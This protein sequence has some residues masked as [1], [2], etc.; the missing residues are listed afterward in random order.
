M[1]IGVSLLVAAIA[2]AAAQ[3]A[4]PR[5]EWS[6][7]TKGKIYASPIIAD[8]EN[9]GRSE[10]I[11]CA[12]RDRRIICFDGSGEVR[13]DYQLHDA[14]GDGIQA[15]PSV[16]D[17]DGDGRKEVFFADE[18]GVVGCL[19]YRGNVVWRV[20]T[21][22]RVDYSGPVVA[23]VNGDGRVEVIF[24]SDS[25]T[26][27][28]LDDAGIE[29][30][31]Y[32]GNGS[33]RGIPAVLRDPATSTMRIYVTFSGGTAACLSSEGKVLWSR[34]EPNAAKPRRSGPALGDLDGDGRIEMVSATGD[35]Q[36]IA[37]D[38]ITGEERWRWKGLL[39]ID[40][41][42]SFALADFD[43]TG[44][45]DV[46]CGDGAGLGGPGHVYRL[47]DGKALWTADVRGG[48]VQGP[49]IGDVDGD[50]ALEIMVCTRENRLVCLSQD[51]QE[52][53]DFPSMAG[54][55]T[56]PAI[57]DV[58]ADGKTEIVFTSKDG[59]VR[60]VTVDGA[61]H[62]DRLPWPC[63]NHDPQL[64]G[65]MNGAAFATTMPAPPSQSPP[66]LKVS[67]FG[68]LRTGENRVEVSFANL[69]Y[70]PRHLE[71]VAE[72]VGPN[73]S[74][75][76]RTISR[77]IQPYSEDLA[78]IA[79]DAFDSGEYLLSVR[80]L[81]VGAG[82]IL[83]KKSD[84]ARFVPL[85]W[86]KQAITSRLRQASSLLSRLHDER[87]KGRAAKAIAAQ[88]SGLEELSRRDA[89][90]AQRP[91]GAPA[92]PNNRAEVRRLA[93]AAHGILRECDRITARLTAA[94]ATPGANLD[95]AAVPV[96]TLR[97]L[98]R[99]EPCLTS[100]ADLSPCEI[101]VAGN[102]LEGIQLVVVPLWKDIPRLRVAVTDAVHSNGTARI[103]AEDIL[104]NRV[105]YV[106]VGPPEYNWY[107]EKRGFY[108]DVLF[109]A[110]PF[111][112]PAD[113]D[114]QPYFV[115]VRAR[116][117][118]VPGDY[119]AAVVFQ[120]EGCAPVTTPLKI[121]VWD[122]SISKETHLKTSLWINEGY[123]QRFYKYQGRTPFEVRK[124]YYD[125]QLEHR[126]GP[127]MALPYGGGSVLEDFDYV[128]S[129]GQNNFFVHVPGYIAESARAP[130]A[131]KLRAIHELIKAKGWNDRALF[132][133]RDEVAVMARHEI[134]Q[135][136]EMNN[137]TRSIVP[138][139]PRLETSAPE[140]SLF[141]AVDIWCPTIDSFDPA[142]LAQ[143]RAKG[144]RLWFYTVWGRPGIMIEFPATD[145]RLMFWQ[146][147]KYGAEGFLYW[148][149]T[150][151]DLNVTTERRWPDI[152]WIPYNRQPGHNGCGYLIYPGPNG[153]PLGSL[154]FELVRDGIEDFEY[155]YLLRQLL[156]AAGERVPAQLRARAEAEIAVSPE[157]VVDH[158]IFTEDPRVILNARARIAGLI[159]Q[160]RNLPAR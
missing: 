34:D 90:V 101:A 5:L 16:V 112:V 3:G 73:Q 13:W 147:W 157:V 96:T 107:V 127:L 150:H 124:R 11:V 114:A 60:S 71:L 146:C 2:A 103:P 66:L 95:F 20:F 139:W 47:R 88:Q 158:K 98:F 43:G 143:R 53:W 125:Y 59:F 113:Q 108:P 37:C 31:H 8:L 120:A 17:Y 102:E 110:E 129:H 84:R 81:D 63:L 87:L 94:A 23:D 109:P 55:L 133:S 42:N 64:S 44:R 122:F 154:R 104:V 67:G 149:T 136:V 54:S 74:V 145:H 126:T 65:S 50:G 6:Y 153:M 111:D 128:L 9:D 82:S 115:T 155:L 18:G 77:R 144:D 40:Q 117:N 141:G 32:Q 148:G 151:W 91:V 21:G 7:D 38:A 100:D 15:T 51:G 39:E 119:R 135:V 89:Q 130:E 22:D 97:K 12:S 138:D 68:P 48:V 123:I 46:V 25:G 85:G 121:H 116:E 72:V 142:V 24:G 62:A 105:G 76:T 4:E 57:A 131:E 41:T 69:S 83:A 106:E 160:L 79:F 134:P 49:S 80:L 93:N 14:A 140:Q 159:E 27:Y 86:E 137:W 26:L 52:E 45:L 1:R 132:Y 75:V 28:C 118:T 70:R 10:V 29:L 92:A 36:V 30:W 56:T 61:Y 156:A 58:D 152:P 33:I 78:R 19:D 99:D 35:F